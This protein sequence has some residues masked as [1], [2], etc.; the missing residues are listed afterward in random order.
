MT[1]TIE[2]ARLNRRTLMKQAGIFARPAGRGNAD[3]RLR[4]AQHSTQTDDLN[5]DGLV[6]TPPAA[7]P[8]RPNMATRGRTP[9][10]QQNS[11]SPPMTGSSRLQ[12]SVPLLA[13]SSA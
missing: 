10:R 7:S 6:I 1:S 4:R 2:T 13:N 8:E 12:R 11:P 5:T 9:G 3:Q